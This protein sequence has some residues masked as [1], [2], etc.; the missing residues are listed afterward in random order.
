MYIFIDTN[1]Y[2]YSAVS[3]QKEHKI[4]SYENLKEIIQN[5]KAILLLPE[6]IKIEFYR[7]IDI[8]YSQ[9][10]DYFEKLKET[11]NNAKFPPYISSDKQILL[12]AFEDILKEKERKYKNILKETDELFSLKN[13][14]YISLSADIF[15]KAY[16]RCLKGEKPFKTRDDDKL[17]IEDETFKNVSW[18]SD[19]LAIESI[20]SECKSLNNKDDSLV[21]C[22]NNIKDF[23]FFDKK[24]KRHS[25]HEHIKRDIKL[26]VNYYRFYPEMFEFEFK[27]HISKEEKK[28]IKDTQKYY[29]EVSKTVLPGLADFERVRKEDVKSYLGL[30]DVL[31]SKVNL[32][33]SHLV[34]LADIE[35][36]R[37]HALTSYIGLADILKEVKLTKSH[38]VSLADLE[39]ARRDALERHMGLADILKGKEKKEES[40]SKK[41][42]KESNEKQ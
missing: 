35:M 2:I 14:K 37:R 10:R 16:I 32:M 11:V 30:S 25:L 13:N 41:N 29:E 19:A 36:A 33:E 38:L 22:C 9:L 18:L 40:S 6:V 34:S 23:A 24:T 39:R 3:S 12:K 31:K 1:N 27:K 21:F 7:I 42:L 5:G 15:M 4:E 26:E 20:I 8:V 17:E 28:A